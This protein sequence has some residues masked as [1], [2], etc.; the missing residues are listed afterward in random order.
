MRRT[1]KTVRFERHGEDGTRVR[2]VAASKG[3]VVVPVRLALRVWAQQ[4]KQH[5]RKAVHAYAVL[6]YALAPRI[7]D[8]LFVCITPNEVPWPEWAAAEARPTP[9]GAG[10]GWIA[11]PTH[12]AAAAGALVR[13]AAAQREARIADGMQDRCNL[14][15]RHSDE[16][17]AFLESLDY[18]TTQ[19]VKLAC[20]RMNAE[21]ICNRLQCVERAIAASEQRLRTAPVDLAN[22]WQRPAAATPGLGVDEDPNLL[23]VPSTEDYDDTALG[24]KTP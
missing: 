3:S 2:L 9:V 10:T 12:D 24:E 18:Y 5:R 21:G 14:I 11:L 15:T 22:Q 1:D 19:R 4:S 17:D 6:A 16:G 7:T 23:C 20:L 13:A 8:G